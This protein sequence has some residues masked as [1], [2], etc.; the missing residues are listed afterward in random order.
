[1]RK[2]ADVSAQSLNAVSFNCRLLPPV[3]SLWP[4]RYCHLQGQSSGHLV[5]HLQSASCLM[6]CTSCSSRPHLGKITEDSDGKEQQPVA[7]RTRPS[8][9]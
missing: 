6:R 8:R 1:M 7:L 3:S 4:H 2:H 9:G 5:V